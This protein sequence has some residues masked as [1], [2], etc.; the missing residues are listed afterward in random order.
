VTLFS[1]FYIIHLCKTLKAYVCESVIKFLSFF[2]RNYGS[3]G[4]Q[5]NL[6]CINVTNENNNN[7]IHIN[8]MSLARYSSF[9]KF[10]L[11]YNSHITESMCSQINNGIFSETLAQM[12]TK[13][14][15]CL[16]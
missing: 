15:T 3:N 5:N 2:F 13:K 9:Q 12:T 1:N 14:I 7:D 10:V 16:A 6:F 8:S 4:G 11:T